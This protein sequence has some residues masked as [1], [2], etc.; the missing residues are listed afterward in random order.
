MHLL[1]VGLGQLMEPI[2][3]VD[4]LV[5]LIVQCLLHSACL[6]SL[7]SGFPRAQGHTRARAAAVKLT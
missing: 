2:A 1:W 4:G 5:D 7:K 3:R 6:S